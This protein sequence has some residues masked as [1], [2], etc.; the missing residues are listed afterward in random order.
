VDSLW[1]SQG[2]A[3]QV[4]FPL[5]KDTCP[6]ALLKEVLQAHGQGCSTAD[7]LSSG[8][9]FSGAAGLASQHLFFLIA[10]AWR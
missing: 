1:H 6:A 8:L 2:S 5:A 10:D 7:D 3:S 9:P 4:H